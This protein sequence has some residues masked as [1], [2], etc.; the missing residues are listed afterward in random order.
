MARADDETRARDFV[1]ARLAAARTCAATAIDA[2]DTALSLFVTPD[3]DKKAKEREE[4]L[5]EADDWL[6]EAALSVQAAQEEMPGINPAEGEPGDEE[7]EDGEA[8]E[9]EDD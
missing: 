4:A 2:I 7:E 5:Q 9:V 6:G 1:M 8:E 3:E